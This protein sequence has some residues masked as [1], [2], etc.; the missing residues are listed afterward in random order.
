MYPYIPPPSA[1]KH[2]ETLPFFSLSNLRDRDFSKCIDPRNI[3][4]TN[5][6]KETS[7]LEPLRTNTVYPVETHTADF[8]KYQVNVPKERL[9]QKY[10]VNVPKEKFISFTNINVPVPTR[11][12]MIIDKRGDYDFTQ[13]FERFS[14]D[15]DD[16][17]LY[18][19]T[20]RK[21]EE[22]DNKPLNLMPCLNPR[23]YRRLTPL[24]N[25]GAYHNPSKPQIRFPDS[26]SKFEELKPK[27]NEILEKHTTKENKSGYVIT[28]IIRQGIDEEEEKRIYIDSPQKVRNENSQETEFHTHNGS[29]VNHAHDPKAKNSTGKLI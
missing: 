1:E 20:G 5:Y 26:D 23:A 27:R 29:L 24:K 7:F 10:Q 16:S 11:K 18:D 4:P 14:Y 15:G 8:Q 3:Q 2:E 28:R 21:K 19:S 13:Q 25:V 6:K 9:I 12:P 22:S 17:Y